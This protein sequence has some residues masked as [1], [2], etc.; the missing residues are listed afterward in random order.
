MCIR[1]RYK[2]F[3]VKELAAK[4]LI[5][6]DFISQDDDEAL[7][8]QQEGKG[9]T[10]VK[11]NDMSAVSA[12]QEVVGGSVQAYDPLAGMDGEDET[13]DEPVYSNPNKPAVAKTAALHQDA[14]EDAALDDL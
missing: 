7:K 9:Y 6:S 14:D 4:G 11:Q 2:D 10:I 12:K 8:K 3:E 13:Y 1:D 5:P